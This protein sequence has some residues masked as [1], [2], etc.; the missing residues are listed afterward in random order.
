MDFE[1]SLNL[2]IPDSIEVSK[3]KLYKHIKE[4]GINYASIISKKLL[5]DYGFLYK[6]KLYFFEV[7]YQESN[8]SVDEKPQTCAFKIYQLTKLAK[9][10]GIPSEDVHYIYIFSD[11]FKQ[12]KYKDMLDYIDSIYNC[13][14]LFK[15]NIEK[16]LKD[17][18]SK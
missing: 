15:E 1:R 13:G 4:Q 5:V 6:N 18:Q 14:Y 16:Y 8:G 9:E 12:E 7:K 2:C 11:W 10:L 3:N 17:I